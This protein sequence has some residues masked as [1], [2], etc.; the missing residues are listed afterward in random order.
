LSEVICNTSPLQYFYQLGML[1]V[2]QA[3]AGH[4]IVPPA[5]VHELAVGRAR[6]VSLPDLTVLEWI[7]V[8]PPASTAVLPLVMDLGPGETEVL[9]LAL[10]ST[11]A[12]VILDDALARQMATTLAIRFRGSLGVLLDAKQAG[13]VSA[14][15]PLLDQLQALGFHLSAE[16]RQLIV[17][18]ANESLS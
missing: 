16:T 13:L 4:I 11:D 10:E 14:I 6:G 3:L 5:V 17:A 15:T 7:T 9:A 2:F 12:I 18:L 1:H 8:R